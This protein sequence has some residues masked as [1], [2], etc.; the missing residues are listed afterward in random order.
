MYSFYLPSSKVLPKS[1]IMESG[2]PSQQKKE[3]NWPDALNPGKKHLL[4]FSVSF[5]KMCFCFFS[6]SLQ[7]QQKVNWP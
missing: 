6:P 5:G 7:Q 4:L 3:D 1:F 2:N